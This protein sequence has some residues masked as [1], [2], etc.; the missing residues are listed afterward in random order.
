MEKGD[1]PLLAI[2]VVVAAAAASGTSAA[3]ASVVAVAKEAARAAPEARE[4]GSGPARFDARGVT[5]SGRRGIMFRGPS[6]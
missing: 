6:S 3:L 1:R 5:R 2:A 4:G